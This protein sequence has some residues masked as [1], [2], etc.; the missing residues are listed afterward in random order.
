MYNVSYLNFKLGKLKF[1]LLV[2]YIYL[3]LIKDFI[4]YI[5]I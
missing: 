1:Y 3:N 2:I 5:I 4:A